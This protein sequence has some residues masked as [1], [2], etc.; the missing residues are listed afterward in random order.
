MR[1]AAS[2]S[3]ARVAQAR[4]AVEDVAAAYHTLLGG[5]DASLRP[6]LRAAM[7]SALERARVA[8]GLPSA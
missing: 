5:V 8:L 2:T 3:D 6:T 7:G 1:E 4:E